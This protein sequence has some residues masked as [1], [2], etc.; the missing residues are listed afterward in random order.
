VQNIVAPQGTA[1][2]SDHARILKRYTNEAVL[3]F[4]S[5]E[6][7]QNAAM[8]SLDNLLASDM[9]DAIEMAGLPWKQSLKKFVGFW[10]GGACCNCSLPHDPDSFIKAY[11][12]EAFQKLVQDAESFFDFYLNRLCS[13]NDLTTDKGRLVILKGMGEAIRKTDNAVLID[14]Y[15]KKTALLLGVTPEAVL[16]EFKKDFYH[17][18][19]YQ[20][21]GRRIV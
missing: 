4:D 14:K 10:F 21:T 12:A 2:T 18:P 7:G 11:G 19:Y 16:S 17:N 13:K 15:T 9:A 3:C 1:F 5:D 8:R 6:A 20:Q